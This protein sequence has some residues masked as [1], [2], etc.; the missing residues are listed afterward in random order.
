[1]GIWR[2]LPGRAALAI[3]LVGSGCTSGDSAS[4]LSEASGS[5]APPSSSTAATTTNVP[6]TTRSEAVTTTVAASLDEQLRSH[7]GSTSF[8]ATVEVTGSIAQLGGVVSY[9]GEGSISG[10]DSELR[11][12]TDF[13]QIGVTTVDQHGRVIGR[14]GL[15]EVSE[16]TIVV[17]GV[18]YRQFDGGRW[19]IEHVEEPLTTVG[20]V[21][22]ELQNVTMFDEDGTRQTDRGLL[23]VMRPRTD[24]EYD[25]GYFAFD[26]NVVTFENTETSVLVTDDGIPVRLE[27]ETDLID[28]RLE[29]PSAM[30]YSIEFDEVGSPHAVHAPP[31]AWLPLSDVELTSARTLTSLVDMLVPADWEVRQE[32]QQFVM[33]STSRGF[34]S[35]QGLREEPPRTVSEVADEI[36]AGLD[37]VVTSVEDDPEYATFPAWFAVLEDDAQDR[38]F[39]AYAE[40]L[41][42]HV[43][44]VFWV[45]TLDEPEDQRAR[46]EEVLETVTLRPPQ[47]SNIVPGVTLGDVTLQRDTLEMLNGIESDTDCSN[48]IPLWVTIISGTTDSWTE[49]WYL[50]ACGDLEIYEVTYRRAPDG[51]TDIKAFQLPDE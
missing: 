46:F 1:M 2:L 25:V 32:D 43:I 16:A 14:D 38:L 5:T 34:V 51:S 33:F 6:T 8:S 40:V 20:W 30:T 29:V 3:I 10:A 39:M 36:L 35:V 48:R 17:D 22:R 18:Q 42:D 28:A 27:I 12:T 13:S 45:G 24:I 26:P 19:V 31:A 7:L 23:T 4:D 50:G 9:T 21:V 11:Q 47:S 41:V 44:L 15:S 49:H 37:F